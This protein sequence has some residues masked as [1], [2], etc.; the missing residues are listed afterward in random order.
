M[1][2]A[3]ARIRTNFSC[4]SICKTDR[5]RNLCK[6]ALGSFRAPFV[7]V[8]SGQL[9]VFRIAEPDAS[10]PVDFEA[11]HLFPGNWQ[12]ASLSCTEPTCT[13]GT[14]LTSRRNFA[15]FSCYE[16]GLAPVLLT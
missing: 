2:C 10:S 5:S 11:S 9:Q 8:M 15:F 3:F 13:P 12:P 16:R 7:F 6:M 1:L 14:V 4:I